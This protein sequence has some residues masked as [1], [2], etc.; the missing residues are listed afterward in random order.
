[1]RGLGNLREFKM[2]GRGIEMEVE[3]ACL[4]LLVLGFIQG[5]F[6]LAFGLD[7]NIDWELSEEGYLKMELLPK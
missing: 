2:T 1:L 7:T 6:E 5:T 3:N 4:P